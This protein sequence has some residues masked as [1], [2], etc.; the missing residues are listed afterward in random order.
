MK[1]KI[2]LMLLL[3]LVANTIAVS[4]SAAENSGFDAYTSSVDVLSALEIVD[5]PRG[6]DDSVKMAEFAE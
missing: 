5:A 1:I 3:A 2:T 4:V 6:A